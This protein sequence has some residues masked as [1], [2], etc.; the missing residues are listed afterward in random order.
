MNY[1]QQLAKI[2]II[3]VVICDLSHAQERI[4][5]TIEGEPVYLDEFLY[6][7]EKTNRNEADFSRESVEEYLDLYKKFKLKVHKAREMKLDTIKALQQ[8]LNGY[9]KQLASAYLSDREV[10]EDLAREAHKRMMRDVSFSHIL[11][12]VSPTAS[13][14]EADKVYQRALN[15]L[16]RLRNGEDFG[17]VAVEVSEDDNA[18]R[19]RGKIGYVTAMLPDGFYDLETAIYSLPA[20]TY[21]RPIRSKLGFHIVT[22]NGERAARGEMEVSQILVRSGRGKNGKPKIDSLYQLLQNGAD[23]ATLAKQHSEDKS[24]AP[25]GGYLGFFGINKYESVFENTAFRLRKDGDFSRPVRSSLGWHIIKR[26]SHKGIPTFEDSQR[27]LEAKIKS[28]GRYKIAEEAM[29]SKIKD[30]NNF[31]END[32]DRSQFLKDIGQEYLTYKWKAPTEYENQELFRIGN[33]SVKAA[34]FLHYLTKNTASR[35]RINRAVSLQLALDQLYSEFVESKLK[36]YQESQLENKH[37]DFKA[38]MR[39]YREGILL[40][41]ATKMKVWDRA[42]QD[43]IGLKMFFKN[44]PNNYMWPERALVETIT[45]NSTDQKVIDKVLKQ[46]PKKSGNKLLKKMNKSVEL[47]KS[48]TVLRDKEELDASLSWTKNALS[49]IDKNVEKGTTKLMRV[50]EIVPPKQ[51]SLEEARGYIIADY[52]D[53]L[54][55]E[56]VEELMKEYEIEVNQEVLSS[57]IK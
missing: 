17:K 35:L 37:P 38:L 4:L 52:Q 33:S 49:P 11:L 5:F 14:E 22:T 26:H 30:E 9:R 43:T 15:V 54:E 44:H 56:W 40:F 21:S 25:K 10:L 41:E 20:N 50:V 31:R 18:V 24:T 51:K 42:S 27:T 1:L 6:I 2:I 48:Q 34:D 55:K 3:L 23:F 45:I 13:E 16:E 12:K 39:E 47:V 46:I 53:Y 57:I 19:N 28:D 32:W 8:E 7:Y 36:E 29:L